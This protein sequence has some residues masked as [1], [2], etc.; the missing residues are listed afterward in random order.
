MP[1][2]PRMVFTTPSWWYMNVQTTA[3]TTMGMT[4]GMN[5]AERKRLLARIC[6]LNSTA[7]P[8]ARTQTGTQLRTT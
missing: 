4:T 7:S 3:F 8:S 6:R 5:A 1:N 2:H